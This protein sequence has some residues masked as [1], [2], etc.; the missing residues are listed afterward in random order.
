MG[1]V[2]AYKRP[3]VKGKLLLALREGKT[4]VEAAGAIVTPAKTLLG[5]IERDDDFRREVEDAEMIGRALAEQRAAEVKLVARDEKTGAD[6]W[7]KLRED[8]VKFGGGMLGFL[9]AVEARLAARPGAHAFSPYHRWM[10]TKWYESGKPVLLACEGRGAGK[11]DTQTAVVV[12]E[13]IFA[14]RN[15]PPGETWIWPYLSKDM[16]ETN[17]KFGPLESALKAVGLSNSDLKIHRR[18][19]GR[20][21]IGFEDAKGH[22]IEVRVYPNTKDA[23]RGPTLCGGTNDE[24]AFWKADKDLGTSTADDV[25]DAM[26]GAFRGDAKEKKHMRI[27]SANTID[28]TLIRDIEAGDDDLHF[29]ARL[30]PFVADAVAGFELVA[31]RLV[32]EGRTDDARTIRQ[33]ASSLTESSP[34]IPSWVGNPTHDVW[35]GFLRLRKRVAKWLR[36]NG[37]KPSDGAEEGDYFEPQT[38][39]RAVLTVRVVSREVDGRFAAIDTGAK[40]NPSALGIVERV[41]HE[42][43]L[44]TS[45][46]ERRYQFRPLVLKQ[47]SR[48]P[49]GLPLDLRNVVLPDMARIILAHGCVPAWWSDG[50]GGDAVEI[51]GAE[52][53]IETKYVDTARATAQIYEPI[54]VALAHDPCPI[55]L[56][57]CENIEQAVAQ[58]R[59]VRRG[60]DGKAIVAHHGTGHGEL[61]QVLARA[62]AHAGVGTSPPDEALDFE[63]FGSNRGDGCSGG[64]RYE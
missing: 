28:A 17:L 22:P 36:E 42:V 18:K 2:A 40:K 5:W 56:S 53:G 31:S 38:I 47:W 15:V 44:G 8:A 6:R 12:T 3:D 59:Q 64:S 26:A 39:D 29:V 27:S 61:G 37:S 24:E 35:G 45:A 63:S 49:G 46:R 16:N 1:N 34:W 54:D 23:L 11:S 14:D 4:R 30:G 33:W 19:D 50:W 41:I 58:L 13:C 7:R 9:F 51:V 20:S 60:N 57:G 48:K 55:V 62:L 32:S 25:L 52:K 10:L 21:E 43:R